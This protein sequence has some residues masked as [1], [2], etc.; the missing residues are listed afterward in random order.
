MTGSEKG[1][2]RLGVKEGLREEML[3]LNGEREEPLGDQ[4]AGTEETVS[5]KLGSKNRRAGVGGRS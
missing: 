4:R 2:S 5:A 1:F 3:Q